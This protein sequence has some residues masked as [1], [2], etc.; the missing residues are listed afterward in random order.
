MLFLLIT[1]IGFA[2]LLISLV[3]GDLF[4]SFELNHSFDGGVDIAIL[5]SRVL[6]VF[7]TAFGGFGAIGVQLGWNALF[8]SLFGLFGG[9]VFGG[10]VAAFAGFL[11]SQ[12]ASSA[13]SNHQL[14]GQTAQVTVSIQAG[15]VG[16]ILCRIG[17]EKI[18]KLAR[19]IDGAPLP[20][21]AMVRIESVGG[22]VIIV[23]AEENTKS[24]QP[25]NKN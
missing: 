18:E 1:G 12:Q 3:V 21:G 15:N 23:S 4:E 9:V 8:C 14:V 20:A 2:F 7:V 16:Q 17:S 25:P 13:V 24:F 19:T 6:A 10:V 5:D 11:S 22:D